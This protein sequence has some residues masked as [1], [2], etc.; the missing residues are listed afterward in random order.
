MKMM[1]I[2]INVMEMIWRTIVST[3]MLFFFLRYFNNPPNPLLI[4]FFLCLILFLLIID[5]NRSVY[6]E[7]EDFY[8]L[9]TFQEDSMLDVE[10]IDK[11]RECCY[12]TR[13]YYDDCFSYYDGFDE[14]DNDGFIWNDDEDYS[15]WNQDGGDDGIENHDD[16]DNHAYG[17]DV[18]DDTLTSRIEDYIANVYNGWREERRTEK[19]FV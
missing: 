13:Y 9:Y 10:T 12:F 2:I 19:L 1:N 4:F 6:E 8:V 3:L 7:T 5:R 17:D 15:Q 14:V 18:D 16:D 11:N